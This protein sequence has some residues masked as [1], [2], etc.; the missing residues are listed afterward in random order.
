MIKPIHSEG[1]RFPYRQIRAVYDE[2]TIT[3]YQAY[4]PGIARPAAEAGRFVPPFKAGR[5][6]WIKPSFLWMMYRCGWAQKPDQEHVLAIQISRSGFEWALE[7][8]ALSHYEAGFH[9]SHEAWADWAAKTTVRIQWDPERNFH[10]AALDYR[11]IQVGLGGD[12]SD[13]YVNEWTVSITD[14]TPLARQIHAKVIA[15]DIAQAAALM[16][17]EKPYPLPVELARKIAAT[18]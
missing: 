11:S 3:V 18:L 8:S 12:A 1:A 13:K 6:T 15:G 14:V 7:H 17:D 5:M 10:F 9:K 4:R 16:P 2:N